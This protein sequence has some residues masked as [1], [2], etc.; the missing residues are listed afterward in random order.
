MHNLRMKVAFTFLALG[1]SVILFY[2]FAPIQ[3]GGGT[4]YV[5]ISGISMEPDIH[6][7]DLIIA[8][9]KRIYHVGD[10]V[11]YRHP[12]GAHI[13]HRIIDQVGDTFIL[14]GDNNDWL[15]SHQPT[16]EEILGKQWLHIPGAGNIIQKLRKPGYMTLIALLMAATITGASKPESS[17]KS[18]RL[19]RNKMSE[20][21]PH[22][23]DSI[24]TH[25][26]IVLILGAL[27]LGALVL[28]VFAFTRPIQRTVA[29]DVPYQ[30]I[31]IL[32]Y[33]APDVDDLYDAE[34]VQTGEPVFLQS[35]CEIQFDLAYQFVADAFLPGESD[36]FSGAYQVH[37]QISDPN[38]W[39][40][41][42]QLAPPTEFSGASFTNKMTFDLCHLRD[43]IADLEERTGT[44]TGWY[45]LSI[46]PHISAIGSV[47][48]RILGEE[49]TPRFNFQINEVM[50]R[51]PGDF[52]EE[53]PDELTQV[54]AGTLPG[55]KT[56]PNTLAIFGMDLPVIAA[57]MISGGGFGLCLLGIAWFGW[58]IYQEWQRGDAS[59][60]RV[61]YAPMLVDVQPGDFSPS[62]QVIAMD[63]I[64]DLAK[65]AE[66][67]GAMIMYE[68]TDGLH[69][70]WV[71]DD[72]VVYEYLL[73]SSAEG[74]TILKPKPLRQDLTDA[75]AEDQFQLFYQP[76]VTTEDDRL[77]AFE[78]FLRWFHPQK[79][80]IYPPEFLPQAEEHDLM[81]E[82]D[83]WVIEKACQQIKAW[84]DAGLPIA[85]I[86][87][88]VS[89]QRFLEKNF[90]GW[91]AKTIERY[92]CEPR[93]L[94]LEVN[95]ANEILNQEASLE[96]SKQIKQ[97]GVD[98]VI[99]NFTASQ[100]NQIAAFTRLPISK[101]KIDYRLTH[102]VLQ[103]PDDT[104]LVASIVQM[105]QSLDID[106]IAEGVETQDQ[107]DF[108]REQQIS[109]VQ[110]FFTGRPMP[111][112]QANSFLAGD[113]K[114]NDQAAGE[115][116]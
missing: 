63:S 29:D 62:G 15:D 61:Q 42:F 6:K 44:N 71:Q 13:F 102:R 94:H 19:R 79:G 45:T 68:E 12:S 7:G 58:P 84:Q 66:R 20:K 41:S 99:D 97:I 74:S 46:N 11:V 109:A 108:L 103:N 95:R 70:Y 33:H 91:L 57:R 9:K 73:D 51:L 106:V 49:I 55:T 3:I 47:G 1:L 69:R 34:R 60:I 14:Q 36:Q 72:Q 50:M 54:Q 78:A 27:A 25:L 77:I 89:P 81:G 93:Y 56:I 53:N 113:A 35:N 17:R 115:E 8:R 28:G 76:I 26:E 48:G 31:N 52:E 64:E 67:Y 16:N 90:P 2:L 23:K 96:H 75:L 43:L 80:I 86:W 111:A 92:D 40:R 85:P 22:P 114:A 110:G 88:N 24:S 82:I 65:L 10:A 59:R 83:R 18:K 107:L 37:A 116:L 101:L 4:S 21:T 32:L 112:D 38:G 100:S 39:N 5:V 98:L 105:A 104:R 87:V 30:H